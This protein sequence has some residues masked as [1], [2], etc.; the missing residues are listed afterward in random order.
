MP[1]ALGWGGVG[2]RAVC[3]SALLATKPP[4]RVERERARRG[5][6]AGRTGGG[7]VPNR[8]NGSP[9]GPAAWG[10][11]IL[12]WRRAGGGAARLHPRRGAHFEARE[13]IPK[14]GWRVHPVTHTVTLTDL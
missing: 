4:R 10:G 7:Q 12:V 3:S 14:V 2:L 13:K 11:F 1:S 9:A 8:E 6:S 5:G